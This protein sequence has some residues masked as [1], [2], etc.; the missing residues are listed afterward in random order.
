MTPGTF[1]NENILKY[2]PGGQEMFL[3]IQGNAMIPMFVIHF[4]ECYL[5]QI[6]R[7]RKYSVAGTVWWKWIVSCFIEGFGTFQRIDAIVKRKEAEKEKAA[8]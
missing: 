4:S 3:W 8:H 5:L 6:T 2:F 1:F 7:L